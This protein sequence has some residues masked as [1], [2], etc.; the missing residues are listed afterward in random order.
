MT[1]IRNHNVFGQLLN[2]YMRA[3]LNLPKSCFDIS[4]ITNIKNIHILFL[5]YFWV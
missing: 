4:H 3:E 2:Y 1:L 5:F